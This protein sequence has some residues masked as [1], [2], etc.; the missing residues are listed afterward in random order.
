[1]LGFFVGGLLVIAALTWRLRGAVAPVDSTESTDPADPARA[2][3]HGQSAAAGSGSRT[4][5]AEPGAQAT[6]TPP[7]EI[8]TPAT[9]TSLPLLDVAPGATPLLQGHD[10]ADPCA[11]IGEPTIPAG[12]TTVTTSDIT[13]AWS[14]SASATGGASD[15]LHAQLH[16][17]VGCVPPW[18][19]EGSAMY[20]D[21]RVPLLEWLRL[22]RARDATDLAE[23]Q[24]RGFAEL[25][26]ERAHRMYALALAM[27]LFA[28]EQSN[29]EGLRP[30]IRAALAAG[31]S[32]P[33]TSRELWDRLFPGADNRVVQTS[34]ARAV[35][36]RARRRARR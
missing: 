9:H 7:A 23:L 18:F 22:F 29:G 36:R 8:A 19:N 12:Y 10:M 33:R 13:V 21:A 1:M 14:P 34:L 11:P 24:D 20:F 26:A 6:Q 27:V 32:S 2:I 30:I 15:I 25:S 4:L 17:G 3:E 16:A 35:R 31:R 28:I 5:S